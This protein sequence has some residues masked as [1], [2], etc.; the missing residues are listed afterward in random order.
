M[1][2]PRSKNQWY[3]KCFEEAISV[4]WRTDSF[5]NPCPD[6]IPEKHF[7]EIYKD[8][9][10]FLT[11]FQKDEPITSIEWIG[12]HTILES[13]D[14]IINGRPCEIKYVSAGL[15]T[16]GNYSIN[17]IYDFTNIPCHTTFMEQVGFL[18]ILRPFAVANPMWERNP[19]TPNPID[20]EA[21][22]KL[23][24]EGNEK[25]V[26]LDYQWRHTFIEAIYDY[27]T[28]HPE[29]AKSFIKACVN[30]SIC[31]KNVPKT[32]CVYNSKKK[33]LQNYSNTALLS[34][35]NNLDIKLNDL[36]ISFGKVR[37]SFYWKN[38]IGC[39]LAMNVFLEE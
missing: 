20:R 35:I 25:L 38:H 12:N 13:G 7:T 21:A 10:K 28:T 19:F 1:N 37:V 2:I 11:I 29:Q 23:S 15:G 27:F 4:I 8:A 14:L 9:E 6:N 34:K 32:L 5:T 31:G 3:G 36:S 16:W 18:D 33:T 30:K 26:R 22:K 39:N 24:E 17:K